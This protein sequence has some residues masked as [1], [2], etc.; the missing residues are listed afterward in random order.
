MARPGMDLRRVGALARNCAGWTSGLQTAKTGDA[1]L[2]RMACHLH[3]PEFDDRVPA[4]FQS[5]GGHPHDLAPA[6]TR[7]RPGIFGAEGILA[8][9]SRDPH[10]PGGPRGGA[11]VLL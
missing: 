5:S 8:T 1:R 3:L 10:L 11:R 6:S 9:H 4:G 2:A 7:P